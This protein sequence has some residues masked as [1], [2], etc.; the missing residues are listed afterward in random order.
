MDISD[1]LLADLD[2]LCA[3]SR[4]GA[5]ID[6]DA[7]PKSAALRATFDEE[8]CLDYALAGGDD[9]EII[10]TVPAAA[11]PTLSHLDV[12][13]TP[14]GVI[15]TG[16]AVTCQRGSAAFDAKRRGYDHFGKDES[17]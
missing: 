16:S 10:F 14:I 11:L 17:R 3:A 15:T 12:Q 4:C 13:C 8:S 5:S 9:Y 7:L 6:I 2:K 1:G